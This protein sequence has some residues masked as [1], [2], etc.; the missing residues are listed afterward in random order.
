M[1]YKGSRM[2]QAFIKGDKPFYKGDRIRLQCIFER[3]YLV[4]DMLYCKFDDKSCPHGPCAILGD[5][6]TGH[7]MNIPLQTVAYMVSE[8][9]EGKEKKGKKK[10]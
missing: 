1:K 6:S 7:F 2:R 9:Q 10:K 5:E 4:V 8:V 3:W